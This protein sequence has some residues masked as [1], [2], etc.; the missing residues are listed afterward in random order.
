[1]PSSSSRP[2]STNVTYTA[3]CRAPKATT[4]KLQRL[5]N[6]AAR[7]VSD[8]RSKFDQRLMQL[9]HACRPPLARR[10]GASETRADGA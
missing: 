6:A 2:T 10:A 1:M 8:T 7:L 5:L 4:D 9:M 3:G